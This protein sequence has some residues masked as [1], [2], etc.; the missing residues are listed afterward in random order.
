MSG[1]T[2]TLSIRAGISLA[3][4]AALGATVWA[5]SPLVIGTA[6][7]WDGPYWYYPIALFV[8]GLFGDALWPSRSGLAPFGIFIGQFAYAFMFLPG[9]PLW[10]I[11][12]MFGGIYLMFA[13]LGSATTYLIWRFGI[14]R[15]QSTN[16][17]DAEA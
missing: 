2:L 12:L 6:E 3:F 16:P 8:A 9:G 14:S 11:G 5:L 1:H 7:P 17:N 10:P 13:F 4:S 15:K